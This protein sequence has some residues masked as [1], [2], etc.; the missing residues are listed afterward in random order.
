MQMQA[1]AAVRLADDLLRWLGVTDVASQICLLSVCA[2]LHTP[3]ILLRLPF[4]ETR[5]VMCAQATCGSQV[6]ACADIRLSGSG[7]GSIPLLYLSQ[8]TPLHQHT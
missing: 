6:S 2:A 3:D 1:E 4:M 7:S 8:P 5:Y